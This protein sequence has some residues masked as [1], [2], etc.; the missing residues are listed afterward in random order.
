MPRGSKSSSFRDGGTYEHVPEQQVAFE[1]HTAANA[2]HVADVL[3]VVE[4]LDYTFKSSLKVN[5]LLLLNGW[6][7]C[8]G[9]RRCAPRQDISFGKSPKGVSAFEGLIRMW[10][11]VNGEST[12]LF[13]LGCVPEAGQANFC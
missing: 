13:E 4:R 1:T 12:I 3:E 10:T 2:K 6:M 8:W 7:Y 9:L 11:W 5:V